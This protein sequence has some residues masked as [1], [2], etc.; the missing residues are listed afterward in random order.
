[1]QNQQASVTASLSR[2]MATTL[3]A[4][5][6]DVA[7]VALAFARC[8]ALAKTID[9]NCYGHGHMSRTEQQLCCLKLLLQG[10]IQ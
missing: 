9:A 5:G 6:D 8:E 7:P 10:S 4:A 1:M 2:I 3:V